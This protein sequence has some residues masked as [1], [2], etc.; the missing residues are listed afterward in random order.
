M[1]TSEKTRARGE[2]FKGALKESAGSATGEGWPPGR[3]RAE[4][5]R[6]YAPAVKEKIEGIF[7]S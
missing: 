2:Q 6:G 1:S 7:R 3:G 4:R 5:K